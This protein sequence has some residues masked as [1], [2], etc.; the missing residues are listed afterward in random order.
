MKPEALGIF[1]EDGNVIYPLC[2]VWLQLGLS[3]TVCSL[4]CS[5]SSWKYSS[6][7]GTLSSS[8]LRSVLQSSSPLSV[9]VS[10]TKAQCPQH[11]CLND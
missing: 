6:Y 11:V 3:L 5:L 10:L 1:Y 4:T 2:F 7:R 8:N 9:T